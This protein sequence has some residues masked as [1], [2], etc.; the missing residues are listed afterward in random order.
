MEKEFNELRNYFNEARIR[1]NNDRHNYVAL[2]NYSK[3]AIEQIEKIKSKLENK[4]EVK[5]CEKVII[6][7]KKVPTLVELYSKKIEH[8]EMIGDGF[9]FIKI[10][11]TLYNN[12]EELLFYFG[13]LE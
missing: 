7:L 1:T 8:P 12:L 11:H 3:K 13:K 9:V 2:A 4:K 5:V 6:E 10:N